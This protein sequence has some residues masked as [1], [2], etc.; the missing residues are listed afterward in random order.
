MGGPNLN[1]SNGSCW[2]NVNVALADEYIP[3]GNA[4][5]GNSYACC[6]YGDNCLSSGACYHAKCV[7]CSQL[8]VQPSGLTN[9][10]FADDITYIAGCTSQDFSGPSCQKK[11]DFFDQSWVGLVR[12][13]PDQTLWAG[14][15]ETG[16]IVGTDPP[17]NC[18]C[19][20]DT[21]LFQ[22][23]PRLDNI[24]ILP[25][26]SGG[27]ISWFANHKPTAA[28]STNTPSTTATRMTYS[29]TVST[30]SSDNPTTGSP[31]T[32]TSSAAALPASGLSTGEK[33]GIGIG[34]AF[35]ALA[36]ICL[37]VIAVILQRR[38]ARSKDNPS[39]QLP[40]PG[41]E[42]SLVRHGSHMPVF[43][44]F[45][46]ELPAY[47]PLSATTIATSSVPG[48]PISVQSP[49]P[50]LY[51]PYRPGVYGNNRASNASQPSSGTQGYS[52]SLVSALSPLIPEEPYGGADEHAP[53]R[54]GNPDTIHE[55]Q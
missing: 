36:V 4:D 26:S 42:P 6:H 2:S 32:S 16:D 47:E 9:T 43:G 13:D 19:S 18:K 12:C 48:S 46:A 22:D 15:P 7:L 54:T 40:P 38:K 5:S 21:V 44:G 20:D 45:K 34:S 27:T 31:Q 33:A 29:T 10:G 39:S 8:L 55:L 3:C 52:E 41:V 14:C 25:Q 51:Q 1:I 23:Q 49:T 35:G 11:G 30:T 24:A 37:I 50:G 17:S 53:S 28:I